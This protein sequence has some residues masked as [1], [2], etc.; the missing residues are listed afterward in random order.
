MADHAYQITAVS[1]LSRQR[2]VRYAVFNGLFP[3]AWYVDRHARALVAAAYK[4][5]R[6]VLVKLRESGWY[7]VKYLLDFQYMRNCPP[8]GVKTGHESRSCGCTRVCPW[9][10]GRRYVLEPFRLLEVALFGAIHMR[11][12]HQ[13]VKLVEF[14]TTYE[15]DDNAE[16]GGMMTPATL[17]D[18]LSQLIP[19]IGSSRREE[20]TLIPN[21][22][23]FVLHTFEPL[24]HQVVLRRSGVLIV[25][26][27]LTVDP[28]D[29][30]DV[31]LREHPPTKEALV[32]IFSR[33]ARF[34]AGW[35]DCPA[36]VTM[37]YLSATAHLRLSAVHGCCRKKWTSSATGSLK[38]PPARRL[39]A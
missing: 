25:D 4:R 26:K 31:E 34:P 30:P 35:Y 11:N 9:C 32:G 13:S 18:Q 2:A 1:D 19:I 38:F 22:G 7:R 37:T 36:E 29:H 15:L 3:D 21:A 20:V 14:G 6:Y 39:M 23:G 10:W 8:C 33:I 24:P 27:D 5:W 17:S 12:C 16:K 28:A